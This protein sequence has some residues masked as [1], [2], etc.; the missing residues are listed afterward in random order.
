MEILA[1]KKKLDTHLIIVYPEVSP[2]G[3]Q[4]P[5][6]YC[7]AL[8]TYQQ[9]RDTHRRQRK[10]ERKQESINPNWTAINSGNRVCNKCQEPF[11]CF[12]L[13][14][15]R[16]TGDWA[17]LLFNW[18]WWS[19]RWSKQTLTSYWESFLWHKH[20]QKVCWTKTLNLRNGSILVHECELELN[21][22][23]LTRSWIGVW[24]LK[25]WI[26]EFEFWTLKIEIITF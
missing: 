10:R 5:H 18:T 8:K 17:H 2:F 7:T 6:Y 12:G 26:L 20:W 15:I 3:P 22:P 4:V 23:H 9:L 19:K 25:F 24:I 16:H 11:G 1:K 14:Q 21:Y 13:E